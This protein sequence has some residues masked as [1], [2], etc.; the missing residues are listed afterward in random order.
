MADEASLVSQTFSV[1]SPEAEA[2]IFWGCGR[3]NGRV[4]AVFVFLPCGYGVWSLWGPKLDC[5][6]PRT[7]DERIF[8]YKIP[9]HAIHLLCMLSIASKRIHMRGRHNIPQLDGT[10]STSTH[11]MRLV[12]FAPRT[13]VDVVLCVEKSWLAP[14]PSW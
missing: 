4:D 14:T 9:I 5:C 3:P 8:A 13:I 6:I 2:K 1:P 10:I 12:I 7:R 11:Q